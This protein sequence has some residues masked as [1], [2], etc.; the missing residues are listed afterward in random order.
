MNRYFHVEIA[1]PLIWNTPKASKST[2]CAGNVGRGIEE[3]QPSCQLPATVERRLIIDDQW[4]ERTLGHSEEPPQRDE[5]A[6]V[7]GCSGKHGHGA[8]SRTS[9]RGSALLGP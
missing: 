9:C 2:E 3:G 7:E 5:A 8:E 4:E 6:P 1:P